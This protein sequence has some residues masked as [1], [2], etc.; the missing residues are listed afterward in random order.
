MENK[1]N[2]P[3]HSDFTS[4]ISELIKQIDQ[5]NQGQ[6]VTEGKLAS[7]TVLAAYNYTSNPENLK[8][9]L[10]ILDGIITIELHNHYN[11]EY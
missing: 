10:G 4:L 6:K 5:Q 3:L 2:N 8:M 11:L 9:A 1:L 7:Q